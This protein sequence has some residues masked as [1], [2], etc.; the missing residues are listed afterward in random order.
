MKI[1][2]NWLQSYFTEKLPEP[3]K[4]AELITFGFAEVE[5]IE[6]KDNDSV[7]DVKVLPDRACYALSHRGVV[8]EI[9]ATLKFPVNKSENINIQVGDVRE[10]V[11]EIEDGNLCRRHIG[12]I[13]EG[14][15]V[16]ESPEWLR[17]RLESVGQRSINNIVD[18]TNFVTLDMG[19][20]LHAFDVDKV[21]GK[22]TIRPGRAG[23]V[24][25]TL[26]GKTIKVDPTIIVIADEEGPLDIAGVK[27]GKKAELD[28]NTKTILL[29][30]AN[31]D[32]SSIRRASVKTG[33]KT[34]ASK[35]FE[36]NLAPEFAKQGADEI[37]ALVL[38]LCPKA[39]A[40]KE[41]DLYPMKAKERVVRF[42]PEDIR[43]KIGAEVSDTEIIEYLGRLRIDVKTDGQD[44]V[45]SIPFER[46]DL[47]IMADIVE[48]VA[49]IYG[50]DKIPAILPPK[51]GGGVEIPKSFYYEWKIREILI[52]AGFSEI[53]NS[54]FSEKGSVAIL[55]PLAEDKSFAR[56]DLRGGFT[57]ALTKNLLNAPLF[58]VD[59]IRVFE[60]GRIFTA[61]GEI[62]SLAIGYGGPKKK[63]A[64]ELSTVVNLLSD[65]L[66]VT[67]N[68]ET[69]DG[70]FECSLDPLFS[71]LPESTNWNILI[72]KTLNTK[73]KQFSLY[74]FIVRDIAL[75]VPSGI[76]SDEVHTLILKEA[77][78]FV[79]RSWLFD[80]FEKPARTGEQ[81]GDGKISYAFRLVFQSSEKTLTDE[82]I[83]KIM[84]KVYTR[85][86][87]RGW[88]VR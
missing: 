21:K 49:R 50:L 26:D 64:P 51:S 41:I 12:R 47:L 58:G 38:G 77:G 36:N 79:V 82:E 6:K 61:N 52:G 66:G 45:A 20:P 65:K 63:V 73:F 67:F 35:R 31:F 14:I 9:S 10:V 55:K 16:G 13:I 25:V 56:Q 42:F 48:E 8:Y 33:V 83:N 22:V 19:Q 84:E 59:E 72:P 1:S 87:E 71:Q 44:W 69:K 3:E 57:L 27:G 54:S 85:I 70:V 2:Y 74:P 23:E 78:E 43:K 28:K 32:P 46:N 76:S 81:G 7:L 30:C 29:S 80:T 24:V 5:S 39:I 75:F 17:S 60:I 62:T 11:I 15:E 68:G 34:D 4:L 18:A 40:G 88:V 86:K 37:T 53:M